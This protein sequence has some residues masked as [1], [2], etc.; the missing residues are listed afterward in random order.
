MTSEAVVA[1]SIRDLGADRAVSIPGLGY[2][3][4]AT[5]SALVPRP[6]VYLSGRLIAWSRG[7]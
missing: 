4:L 3:F 7:K 1:G 6:V 2:R 5:I